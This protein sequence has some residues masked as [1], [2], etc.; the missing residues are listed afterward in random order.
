MDLTAVGLSPRV[1]TLCELADSCSELDHV[2]KNT[3][4]LRLLLALHRNYD[5]KRP[6][7]GLQLYRNANILLAHIVAKFPDLLKMNFFKANSKS[8]KLRFT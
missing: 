4:L 8:R 5:C 3:K 2:F 6:W 7:L 1:G